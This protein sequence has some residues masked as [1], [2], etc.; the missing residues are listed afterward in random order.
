MLGD[1]YDAPEGP[2]IV[3]MFDFDKTLIEGYSAK[4]FLTEQ[5]REG[6]LSPRDLRNQA[7]AVVKFST[8]RANFSAFMA[9]TAQAFRGQAEYKF[10][11]FGE[12]VYRKKV[13]GAIYPEARELLQAHKDMGHTIAIVSSATK[14]Q[15]EPAARELG[16]E[17]ILCTDLEI[18]D[19]IFT[20]EVISP[21]CFGKGKRYAGEDF[22]EAFDAD[23]NESFFYTDSEDDLPLLEVV[24]HPRV[25]NPSKKLASVARSRS[26][27]VCNFKSGGRPSLAQVARTAGIY[28][29]LPA[30]MA[31]TAPLWALTGKKREALN[32]SMGIWTDFSAALA[33]LELDV[34]GEEHAWSHRPCV[35]IF[36]HQ[37]SMDTVIVGKILRRDI[38]GIGKKEIQRF[39]VVGAAL[40]YA[41]MVF[42][43]RSSTAKAID[44]IR[45]V[46]KALKE[47]E[48]SVVLAPEGTR[49]RGRTLGKFKKGA[50]HIAMQA[51]VPI[52]P[53]VIH[54]AADALPKGQNIARPAKVKVTILPPVKTGRWTVGTLEKNIA[55]VR[56]M[57]LDELGQ[58]DDLAA[59]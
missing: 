26:Y 35:F 2:Q 3:A 18:K 19:G 52:V 41:D 7:S 20:G 37:S 33:G 34:V 25:V 5:I 45:P 44:Q 58:V 15:I 57:Y 14:Y 59:E 50:F 11:E 22:C 30:S 4:S 29:M 49:S 38:T 28:A 16:I 39:P 9:E 48:L 54:N 24:G 51:G 42:V 40:T 1:I 13:A 17:Y 43:D 27:P 32:A 12:R 21:T 55:R 46:I 10:E 8:G 47:D 53:I 56:D 6:Q 23:I 36:N 31:M